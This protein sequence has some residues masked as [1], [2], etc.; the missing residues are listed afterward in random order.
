MYFVISTVLYFCKGD[1]FCDFLFASLHTKFLLKRGKK[2]LPLTY[3]YKGVYPKRKE[4]APLSGKGSTLKEKKLLPRGATSFLLEQ[5]PL[6]KG[7]K[8][9]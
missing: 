8:C 2:W 7:G 6:Q 4:L 5:T 9:F 3:M 1:N